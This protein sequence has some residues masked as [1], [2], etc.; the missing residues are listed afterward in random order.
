MAGFSY[1]KTAVIPFVFGIL[2]VI[3]SMILKTLYDDGIV[4][5][6]MITGTITISDLMMMVVVLF[7]VVGV[8]IAATRR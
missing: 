1:Y 7:F 5:D 3:F 6:E 8:I 4:V 2:G